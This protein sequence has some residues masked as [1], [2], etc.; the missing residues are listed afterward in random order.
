MN[1]I[2]GIQWTLSKISSSS[3]DIQI[4]HYCIH[5]IKKKLEPLFNI[6][7]CNGELYDSVNRSFKKLYEQYFKV[8]MAQKGFVVLTSFA[9]SIFLLNDSSISSSSSSPYSISFNRG[10]KKRHYTQ[11]QIFKDNH[12]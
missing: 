9:G 7:N 11:S 3:S 2:L 8:Q 5:K 1:L 4:H 6:T 10:S 12:F